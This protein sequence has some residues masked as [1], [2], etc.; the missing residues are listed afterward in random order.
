[1][2][3]WTVRVYP[4]RVRRRLA[5]RVLQGPRLRGERVPHH[6]VPLLLHDETAAEPALRGRGGLPDP[7][8][9]RRGPSP[10]IRDDANAAVGWATGPGLRVNCAGQF[11]SGS[12]QILLHVGPRGT[13]GV[14]TGPRPLRGGDAAAI[15]FRPLDHR[16]R[17]DF[18]H[19][20]SEAADRETDFVLS[21]LRGS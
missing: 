4:P 12:F 3:G 20:Q 21:P 14:E 13:A 18:S 9:L 11:R 1:M 16:L 8:C 15:D 10:K 19:A 6:D 17:R 5:D 7:L 2:Q